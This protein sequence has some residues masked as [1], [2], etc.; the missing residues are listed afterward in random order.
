MCQ[1]IEGTHAQAMDLSE[2]PLV[3][4]SAEIAKDLNIMRNQG[5]R[6]EGWL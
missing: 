2:F 4:L 6:N 3:N 1:Y 5:R